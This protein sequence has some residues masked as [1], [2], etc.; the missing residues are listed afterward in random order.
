M[1]QCLLPDRPIRAWTGAFF[2]QC[3]ETKLKVD[4]PVLYLPYWHDPPYSVFF[5][6]RTSQALEAF[7]PSI[8]RELWSI[9]PEVA[10]PVIKS[11]NSQMNQSVAAERFQTILLSCFGSAALM[12]AA[13]DINGVLAYSV[14]LRSQ[15]FGVRFALGSTKN[16]VMRLVLRDASPPVLVGLAIGTIMAVEASRWIRGMLYE[17]ASADPAVTALSA[18]VL[19]LAALL[20][21]VLPAYRASKS[22]P[23]LVLRQE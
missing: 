1:Q 14:S 16:A 22:D 3:G 9:D 20:A 11:I 8:R 6:I 13:L 17:T 7:G 12:L 18:G 4:A 19:M 15:E 23:I 2:L 21:A 5:L 10:I